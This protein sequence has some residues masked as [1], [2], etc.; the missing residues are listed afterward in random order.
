MSETQEPNCGACGKPV[1]LSRDP[2]GGLIS[3]AKRYAERMPDG[4][5][6]LGT[7]LTH[8]ACIAANPDYRPEMGE[9]HEFK[10]YQEMMTSPGSEP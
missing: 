1:E 2:D 9:P 5:V 7:T 3:N 4:R 6:R 8:I 10:T